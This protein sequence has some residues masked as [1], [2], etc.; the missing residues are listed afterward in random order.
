MK[1]K[2]ISIGNWFVI[3]E[4]YDANRMPGSTLSGA[5]LIQKIQRDV[6][7][8]NVMSDVCLPPWKLSE[9]TEVQRILTPSQFHSSSKEGKR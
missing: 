2:E 1:L 5:T 4:N 9:D 3:C 6:N 7:G 8:N